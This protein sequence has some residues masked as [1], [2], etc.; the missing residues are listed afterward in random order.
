ML[1]IFKIQHLIFATIT[2][3]FLSCLKKPV[4]KFKIIKILLVLIFLSPY[5]GQKNV[6][7]QT[8]ELE[9]IDNEL[10]T[11]FKIMIE[12]DYRVRYDSLAPAFKKKLKNELSKRQTFYHSFD[13]L[14]KYISIV[15]S[16]D[17]RLK[18]FSWDEKSGGSWHSMAVFA[19]YKT[20]SGQIIAHQFNMNDDEMLVGYTDS[21]IYEISEI[22]INNKK[23]YLTFAWGTHGCG[24]HH[25]IAQIFRIKGKN[26]IKCNECFEDSIDLVVIAQRGSKFN[27]RFNSKTNE[28][29]YNEYVFKDEYGYYYSTG[30]Q[31]TLKLENNKFVK[32]EHM[33][34]QNN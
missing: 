34:N 27:I 13:S 32:K 28:I 2:V 1:K 26:L 5:I 25:V 31:V 20:K 24:K 23:H 10:T 6:F 8:T 30:S 14:S 4:V 15:F 33:N 3:F 16:N 12:A 22:T 21:K 7:C 11:A 19:Q 18:T 17:Q 9:K 29:S